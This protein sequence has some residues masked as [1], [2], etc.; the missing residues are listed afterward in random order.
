VTKLSA[1]LARII[2]SPEGVAGLEA[3]SLMPVGGSAEAFEAALR[4]DYARW[5]DVVKATGV[6][7]E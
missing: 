4:R 3:V 2:A 6:K 1:E 5:A 7:G